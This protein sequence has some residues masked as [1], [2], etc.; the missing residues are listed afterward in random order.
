MK[1]RNI[2]IIIGVAIV[3]LIGVVFA[4]FS[5]KILNRNEIQETPIEEIDTIKKYGYTLEDRDTKYYKSLFEELKEL[6]KENEIDYQKYS[7]TIGKMYVAD[8]YT[9]SNKINHYDV[10]GLEF[11]EESKRENFEL[12][13]QDTLYKYVEDNTYGKR[14]QELP[15]VNNVD[16]VSSTPTKVKF[17]E[18]EY[19]GYEL[20]LS[21]TYVKDLEYDSTSKVSVAFINEKAFIVKQENVEN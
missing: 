11:I 4:V 12:K 18:K 1:R 16:I 17:D 19:D 2:L 5:D 3:L 6:L 20:E 15:E 14:T 8:F 7:E 21:W 9:L 10:G 13:A